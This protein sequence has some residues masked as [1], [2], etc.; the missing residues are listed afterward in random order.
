MDAGVDAGAAADLGA[1]AAAGV[2]NEM[3]DLDAMATDA[4]DDLDADA[5]AP[6]ASLGRARR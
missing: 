3:D 5:A 6:A 1:D 4:A 2:G